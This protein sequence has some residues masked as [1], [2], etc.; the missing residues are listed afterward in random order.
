MENLFYAGDNLDGL[1]LIAEMGI[2]VDLVYIDPPFA[3]NNEF[4]I[5]DHRANTVSA[6]GRPA[7]SDT[8]RGND[9][10][11]A[12]AKRLHS[13]RAVMSPTG[14]IYVHID[15]KMEHHVRLLMDEVFGP[16]NFRNAITRIKCNPKN[17]D[18][19][20]YGNVKD[21]I[22][23][24]SVSPHGIT[25]NPHKEPMSGDDIARLYPHTDAEGRKICDHAP[26]RPW[27]HRQW[28]HRATVAWN[29]PTTRPPLALCS[30]QT[31][32]T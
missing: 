23:F 17:F 13:I 26:S 27:R 16:E 1:R 29:E 21:T 32:R 9:Y 15:V 4:L 28:P 5:D 2:Y 12:L 22:L 24:Y 19:Y 10:L 20:S 31:G 30:G 6:S 25:W 3:T 8:L 7:Y 14:S 18:R 11:E